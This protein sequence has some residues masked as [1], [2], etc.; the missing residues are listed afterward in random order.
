MKK[1]IIALLALLACNSDASAESYTYSCK[2]CIFPG[3]AG[4]CDVGEGKAYLLKID[5][6]RNTL[7]WRGK[8]YS[9]VLAQMDDEDGGCAKY[10]WRAKGN[11]VSF[12]FCT[13]T[14]GYGAIEV[15]AEERVQCQLK[16]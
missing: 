6:A 3:N 14:K 11:G 1:G 12:K 4:A 2:A 13:A 5:D 16:R 9:I 7:D 8:S 10:G 15:G